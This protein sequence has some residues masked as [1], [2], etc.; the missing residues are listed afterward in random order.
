M[1]TP[2]SQESES[3]KAGNKRINESGRNLKKIA[4]PMGFGSTKKPEIYERLD[5]LGLYRLG[6]EL[7]KKNKIDESIRAYT[8]AVELNLATPQLFNNIGLAQYRNNQINEAIL[9][10]ERALKEDPEFSAALS[11]LGVALSFVGRNVEAMKVFDKMTL[12]YPGDIGGHFNTG[13]LYLKLCK[14]E[15]AIQSFAHTIK[16]KKDHCE[17]Y[18]NCGVA[19]LKLGKIDLALSHFSAAAE[20]NPRLVDAHLNIGDIF[21]MKREVDNAISSYL[22]VVSAIPSH[23]V[24]NYR[25]GKLYDTLDR[26][27][28]ALDCY[29]S[30][31]ESIEEDKNASSFLSMILSVLNLLRL[32]RI[33]DA[34]S[35]LGR[36][37]SLY[38]FL[39]DGIAELDKLDQKNTI[40]YLTYLSRLLPLIPL[41]VP[42]NAQECLH[43]GDSHC[44]SFINQE[45]EIYGQTYSIAPRLVMGAKAWHLGNSMEN[46][47]KR[48]FENIIKNIQPGAQKIFL[49]FGEIDCRAGGGIQSY[50]NRHQISCSDVA[51][52]TARDYFYYA[53][54]KLKHRL[55]D[56]FF[57]GP[58]PFVLPSTPQDCVNLDISSQMVETVRAFSLEMSRLCSDSKAKFINTLSFMSI[59]DISKNKSMMIDDY[60]MRP[61]VIKLFSKALEI[62]REDVLYNNYRQC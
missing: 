61:E 43:I 18:N 62:D 58:P 14:Y 37:I 30:S 47:Y 60:H 8:K 6:N 15:S 19:F 44:L 31:F 35:G 11:N 1:D 22:L 27:Q 52:K 24:A 29:Q 50:A 16:L 51:A 49:S 59:D 34:V 5:A 32:G 28:E 12:L 41:S 46:S 48:T 7:L 21:T 25:L 39:K 57:L 26:P 54:N 56:V 53:C 9:S 20:I 13:C 36:A 55:H 38:P 10:Y 23:P 3:G 45:V 42:R 40:A 4:R 2:N 17:A 33:E